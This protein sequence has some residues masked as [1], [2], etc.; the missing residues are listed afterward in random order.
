MTRL[1]AFQK[2]FMNSII[3]CITAQNLRKS[4]LAKENSSCGAVSHILSSEIIQSTFTG[5]AFQNITYLTLTASNN[6]ITF[7]AKSVFPCHYVQLK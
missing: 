3:S 6:G 4:L 1:R 2:A 5:D 7:I